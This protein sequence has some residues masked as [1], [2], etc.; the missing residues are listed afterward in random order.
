[1]ASEK[2]VATEDAI[3]KLTHEVLNALNNGNK[4]CG[5]FCDLKNLKQS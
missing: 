3:F 1:L 2:K 5:I 4:V